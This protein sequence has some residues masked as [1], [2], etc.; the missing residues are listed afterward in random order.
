[1]NMAFNSLPADK[2]AGSL[3]RALLATQDG[4]LPDLV[5]AVVDAA[6]GGEG[7][8]TAGGAARRVRE[9]GDHLETL[10]AHQLTVCVLALRQRYLLQTQHASL[11]MVLNMA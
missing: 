10:V 7:L 1:M 3:T 2:A 6:L 9:E 8:A 5:H 4:A 11:Y